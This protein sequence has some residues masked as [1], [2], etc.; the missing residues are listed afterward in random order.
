MEEERPKTNNR[1]KRI[2]FVVLTITIYAYLA[3]EYL[4]RDTDATRRLPPGVI[5][6]YGVPFTTGIRAGT[7]HI[8][9]NGE[10]YSGDATI[11]PV[12]P[13][14]ATFTH[15]NPAVTKIV[16][17]HP[18]RLDLNAIYPL[19]QPVH[20]LKHETYIRRSQPIISKFFAQD[21]DGNFYGNTNLY[22]KP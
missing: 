6:E 9:I 20:L 14:M 15:T 18:K 4:P 2:V 10:S 13:I 19:N 16:M 17:Q 7:F 1:I 12:M 22:F 8:E 21:D 5:A 11:S 3:F